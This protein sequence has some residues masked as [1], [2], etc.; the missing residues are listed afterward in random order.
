MA[1]E[2]R[3]RLVGSDQSTMVPEP[4]LV[5]SA[6]ELVAEDPNRLRGRSMLSDY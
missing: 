3:Y 1:L 5:D 6:G 2:V 4:R